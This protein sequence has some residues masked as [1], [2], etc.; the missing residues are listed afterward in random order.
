MEGHATGDARD[1]LVG[2]LTGGVAHDFNNVL[3]TVLGC[4]ELMER[5]IENPDRLRVLIQRATEAVE[6]AAE[7]TSALAQFARR[8]PEPARALDVNDVVTRLHPLIGSALGRRVRL[9]TEFAP[10]IP[11]VHADLTALEAAILG[12]C[13]AA[14]HALANGGQ[15][16]LTTATED[17]GVRLDVRA[18]GDV[19]DACDLSLPEQL[20]STIGGTLESSAPPGQHALVVSLRLPA[21]PGPNRPSR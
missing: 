17:R 3:A 12:C 18:E 10:A 4:L 2:Q 11:P 7:L 6:R 13:L 9:T 8:P 21:K 15:I 16:G 20:A 14:R 1:R 19:L 5:R